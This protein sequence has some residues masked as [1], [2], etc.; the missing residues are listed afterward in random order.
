M[1]TTGTSITASYNGATGVLTLSGADTAAH[2]QSVLSSVTFT[3]TSDNPTDYG[4]DTSRT[5]TFTVNDG[6]LTGA[7]QTGTVTVVG[8]NDAP[9]LAGTVNASFTENAAAVTPGILAVA[10]RAFR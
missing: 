3:S 1:S 7:V 5:L 8:V 4:S 6:L 10:S 2:Y 9:T